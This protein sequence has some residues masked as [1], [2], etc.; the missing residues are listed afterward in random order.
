M[1]DKS[2]FDSKRR[3]FGRVQVKEFRCQFCNRIIKVRWGLGVDVAKHLHEKQCGG[4]Q[5]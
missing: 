3:A 1:S 2:L 4:V 5:E